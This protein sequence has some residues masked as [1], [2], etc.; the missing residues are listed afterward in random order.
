M[1]Q[2]LSV[3]TNIWMAIP[4]VAAALIVVELILLKRQIAQDHD[5]SRRENTVQVLSDWC[6]ALREETNVAEAIVQ[7]LSF[8]DCQHLYKREP[9]EMKENLF[10]MLSEICPEPLQKTQDGQCIVQ[11][12]GLNILRWHVM[13]YLNI[14]ETT[15][16]AWKLGIVERDEIEQQFSFLCDDTQGRDFLTNMRKAADGY[17]IIE[18][19]MKKLIENKKAAEYGHDYTEIARPRWFGFKAKAHRRR[20]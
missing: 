17:P 5:R 3:L 14:L 11:G 19:F 16:L 10:H 12:E 4:T 6:L 9:F 18:E 1:E 8:E 2:V 7:Q 13:S 20:G 15:L